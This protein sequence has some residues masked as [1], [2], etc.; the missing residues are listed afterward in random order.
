LTGDTEILWWALSLGACL[1]GNGTAIGASA[2][3]TVIGLAD[4]VKEHITFAQFARFG[5][6]VMLLTLLVST[7]FISAHLFLGPRT[8]H[9]TAFSLLGVVVAGR[10]ILARRRAIRAA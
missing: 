1:G 8:T 6:P 7:A 3:V 2:N 5:T 4:R 10:L 9:L